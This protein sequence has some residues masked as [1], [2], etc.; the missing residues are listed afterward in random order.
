M[1]RGYYYFVSLL[2]NVQLEFV[3]D[4]RN[5]PLNVP[6]FPKEYFEIETP[7][8]TF[9]VWENFEGGGSVSFVNMAN[10]SGIH[11][12]VLNEIINEKLDDNLGHH[13][14]DT[15]LSLNLPPKLM[16]FGDQNK[17]RYVTPREE[18]QPVLLKHFSSK[19]QGFFKTELYQKILKRV[20]DRKMD[21]HIKKLKSERKKV[22]IKNSN[23]YFPASRANAENLFI[24]EG[25]CINE[26]EKINVWRGGSYLSIRIADVEI[27]DEVITHLNRFRKITNKQKKL[28]EVIEIKLKNG[29]SIKQTPYHRYYCF[30]KKSKQFLFKKVGDIDIDSDC[31]VKS[32]LSNF[33]GALRVVD[34]FINSYS[35]HPFVFSLENGE[36]YENTESHLYSIYDEEHQEFIM[37]EASFIKKGDLIS[38]FSEV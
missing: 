24:V 12:K 25:Q 26:D 34:T 6:I 9:S 4:G 20:E 19:L 2:K 14:Y 17:T 38:V 23:K 22:N 3:F 7:I 16:K 36:V 10:C 33:I 37:K 18:I 32:K 15:Y 29:E 30:D 5:I 35:K 11:Q 8:G 21:G 27:G 13:F 28:K 1:E 31:L